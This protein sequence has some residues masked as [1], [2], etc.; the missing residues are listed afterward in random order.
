MLMHYTAM[1]AMAAMYCRLVAVVY[2]DV[3]TSTEKQL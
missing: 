3:D 1:K 2:S